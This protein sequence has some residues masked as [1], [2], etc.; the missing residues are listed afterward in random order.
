MHLKNSIWCTKSIFFYYALIV[1][2]QN[3]FCK[4]M[5]KTLLLSRYLLDEKLFYLFMILIYSIQF[6]HPNNRWSKI[7]S[8]IWSE[9][10]SANC[11][12]RWIGITVP[13]WTLC[14]RNLLLIWKRL[15]NLDKGHYLWWYWRK[16]SD[17]W[18]V[19]RC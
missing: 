8:R 13:C 6:T 16:L 19:G 7:L 10:L 15:L 3:Q 14:P 4:R 1:K 2:L 18:T 12:N 11:M 17:A 9:N 5:Y